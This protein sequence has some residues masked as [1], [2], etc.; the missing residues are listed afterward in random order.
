MHLF[1]LHIY[2][3]D[4]RRNNRIDLE[5]KVSVVPEGQAKVDSPLRHEPVPTGKDYSPL[6][7][8]NFTLKKDYNETPRRYYSEA[9]C[10]DVARRY[11]EKLHLIRSHLASH[12][13]KKD[14]KDSVLYDTLFMP[15][16]KFS[17]SMR[18]DRFFKYTYLGGKKN[19][20][21]FEAESK[22]N[23]NAELT[24]EFI[25]MVNRTS[26]V[27]KLC[28]HLANP[29][30]H[31][32]SPHL[33]VYG[34]QGCGKSFDLYQLACMMIQNR[35]Y[36]VV[37][38]NNAS[39]SL[40]SEILD[41]IAAIVLDVGADLNWIISIINWASK[42]NPVCD[43]DTISEDTDITLN[44]IASAQKAI[45][46][47][48]NK[49]KKLEDKENIEF[50]FLID[51]INNITETSMIDFLNSLI[52]N[53]TTVYSSSA[54]NYSN[55][56]LK[57]YLPDSKINAD[58]FSFDDAS[59]RSLCAIHGCH[60]LALDVLA[61]EEVVATTG[62]VALQLSSFLSFYTSKSALFSPYITKT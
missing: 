47:V 22:L 31:S 55:V 25:E 41:V 54:N 57:K 32:S 49:D 39:D 2:K 60:E 7:Q 23:P 58:L 59:F 6:A 14:K 4:D 16:I 24:F 17:P 36:H 10:K 56:I 8:T 53:Y 52:G 44:F 34:P 19:E 3:L 12:P 43:L 1:P 28:A 13:K 42:L 15:N 29:A 35:H 38:I 9:S 11:I 61:R 62:R 51:Q 5:R 30:A 21:E 33:T 46:Q 18:S 45:N 37:Y 48:L 26:V 40:R 27:E 50:V 20:L